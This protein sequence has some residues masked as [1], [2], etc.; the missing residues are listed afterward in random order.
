[1]PRARP[2]VTPAARR[3]AV[4]AA[5]ALA[6]GLLVAP[7]RAQSPSD[8]MN[9]RHNLSVSGT[10]PIRALTEDRVC[11][12]CHT[13]HNATPLSPL[14]N[15]DL[16]P[17][18]YT[19]Y[20]SPTLR[21]A[22]LPQPFGP[23]KLCL[24]CHDGTI[25]MGAV[26]NPGGGISMAGSD[27]FPAGSLSDFGLDL[28]GHHPVSFSY[29]A[30]L[31]N[32]ELASLPPPDLVFGGSD[33]VH[34]MTC[35][36][37]H[38]DTEGRFLVKS[39][40]YSALCT[41]CHQITGWLGSAHATS[42][43][44]VAGILPRPPKTWPT[45]TQ[46]NEWG[47]E[48]CHTPHFAPT[49]E[50]LLNFTTAPPS[51]FS[52]TS[53]GCHS[54]D[55]PPAHA[56]AGPAGLVS[57][58]MP[59]RGATGAADI[60]GQTRKPSAHRDDSGTAASSVRPSAGPART[61]VGSVGCADCHNPHVGT[62]QRAEAPYA[63]GLLRGVGGVDRNGVALRAVTYE[64]E[65]C[66]R[67][68]GDFTPDIDFVPR[69][70]ATTNTRLA[71]DTGNASYHP[72][73]AMGRNFD[74]PSIPSSLRPAMT[75]AAVIYCTACHA[76]DEGVSRGPHGSAYPPILKERYETADGNPESYEAYALCY[77][78]HE[79]TSILGDAS[80]RAKQPRTTASGGGHS[81]HLQAGAPCS[82]CHDPHGVYETGIAG[83]GATGAHTALINFD[84]RFVQPRPGSPYPVFG[85]D[86]TF[87]GRCSL[88]CHGVDHDTMSY[89]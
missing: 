81:G 26:L 7:A 73:V 72:V 54:S 53:A 76:D 28:S 80:F 5:L 37:P 18:A 24:S 47:C 3:L 84:T 60:A 34:C 64:Y 17:Q 35:H 16:E 51:P 33:E 78:C 2:D 74:I 48:V 10:G 6:G 86:G 46:L 1:M 11:I 77:R 70:I 50:Q 68:H 14:W 9:T 19:V 25:A 63:S 52:C 32:A 79:R 22:P 45:Y 23:T 38:N 27:R 82:V 57:P 4:V 21:A 44:S 30:S 58:R 56:G 43:A 15:K 13:P 61:G 29:S 75:P 65:V 85:D 67:C 40:R 59:G 55:P 39:N 89:P 36:D 12:F 41:T 88:V 49:A 42:T 87:A 71:F 20:A 66:F 69:V 83:A 8:I 31:P 62:T